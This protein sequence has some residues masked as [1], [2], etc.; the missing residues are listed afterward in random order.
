MFITSPEKFAAWFN[1]KHPGAPRQ[2]TA[3]DGENL[4]ACKLI[5]RY[6][7]YFTSE[8]GTLAINL[9]YICYILIVLK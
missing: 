8:D 7:F 4:K 5:H 1:E 2:I 6:G 9:T 3:V